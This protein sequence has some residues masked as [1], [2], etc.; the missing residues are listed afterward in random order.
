MG[1]N[2][3]IFD[4]IP[5]ISYIC[6]MKEY[7]NKCIDC[8][9]RV[10]NRTKRCRVC[11]NKWKDQT[12]DDRKRKSDEYR[13]R[14]YQE[15]KPRLLIKAVE[16]SKTLTFSK[17]KDYTIKSK[18]GVSIE[19]YNSMLIKCNNKCQ[20]C[21][22]SHSEEKPL[23]IDHCHLT[24]TVRGLLCRNCN[25]GLGNFCDNIQNIKNALKYLQNEI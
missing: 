1:F 9:C 10:D 4:N 14:W 5:H 16:R 7:K 12:K 15:N 25:F 24:K 21:G 19:Q 6:K 8:S 22:K 18:Y 3:N 23:H 2:Q 13:R 20:I 17:R 11:Y